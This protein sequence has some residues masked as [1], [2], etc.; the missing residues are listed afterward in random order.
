MAEPEHEPALSVALAEPKPLAQADGKAAEPEL[1]V[2][3]GLASVARAS[4]ERTC[5]SGRCAL[6]RAWAKVS[7]GL[8]CVIGPCALSPAS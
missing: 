8:P 5:V 1:T 2:R 7:V 6:Q 4:A 3:R